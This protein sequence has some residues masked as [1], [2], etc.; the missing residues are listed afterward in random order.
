MP[1]QK[2]KPI[3]ITAIEQGKM[4]RDLT[5]LT[6]TFAPNPDTDPADVQRAAKTMTDTCMITA[7]E[8]GMWEFHS[9]RLPLPLHHLLAPCK[10]FEHK[11]AAYVYL[12]PWMEVP[13]LYATEGVSLR[14]KVVCV[15]LFDLTGSWTWFVCEYDY[16]KDLAFG[17]VH[18]FEKEWGYID[19]RELR[20]VRGRMGLPIERDVHWQPVTYGE[21]LDRELLR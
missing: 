13:R 19:M 15:G 3:L 7:K 1:E 4:M 14:E 21:M 2:P 10:G 6:W 20:E 11:G 5:H 17:L 18:G 8:L 16:E 9:Q 12:P